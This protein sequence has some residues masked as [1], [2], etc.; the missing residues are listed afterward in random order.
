MSYSLLFQVTRC[1]LVSKVFPALEVVATPTLNIFSNLFY[2]NIFLN[3]LHISLILFASLSY[4][5]I[6]GPPISKT[7]HTSRYLLN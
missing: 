5:F 1:H 7:Q 4:F 2:L 6:A 3:I